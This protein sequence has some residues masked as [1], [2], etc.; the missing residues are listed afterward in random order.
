MLIPAKNM[1]IIGL[2]EYL[3]SFQQSGAQWSGF[4]KEVFN[5]VFGALE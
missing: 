3:V 4:L 1:M 5:P 2:Q